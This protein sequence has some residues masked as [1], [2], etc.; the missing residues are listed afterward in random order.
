MSA[1]L[2]CPALECWQALFGDTVAPELREGYEQH[3]E[4]CRAC[5]ELL[6]RADEGG[7]ALR[8]LARQIGDPTAVPAD[9]TLAQVLKRLHEAKAPVR[10]AP[11]E[12]ADLY[13]LRP[14]DRPGV[15]GTLGAYEVTEVIGQGGMGVVLKAFEPALHRQVAIKVLAPAVAGSA[16]ARRRFTREAKAAAAVCHEHVVTVHGVSET[17]GLPY[18]VM[19]YVAGE[20][21]Q[22]RLDR[23][24][25][26][27]VTEIVRIG[28]QTAAG[29]AAAHGQGLIHRDIKPTNLLLEGAP[30]PSGAGGRVKITDFGLAR[31]ADDVGLTQDGVVAGTP[32]YMAPEQARGGTLS[33]SLMAASESPGWSRRASRPPAARRRRYFFR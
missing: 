31:T 10:T 23:I 27:D 14:A 7:D 12:A 20:S 24:G 5:Q 9:P 8:S 28:L 32:E 17:D 15:L 33:G 1:S 3:L 26:L 18:L 2:D 21:L 25:P 13:F 4:S 22:A 6:H 16:S 19:Q 11:L 30:C 29:L